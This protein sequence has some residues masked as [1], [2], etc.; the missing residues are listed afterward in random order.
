MFTLVLLPV[1]WPEKKNESGTGRLTVLNPLS[2][3]NR[4]ESVRFR[5]IDVKNA[6]RVLLVVYRNYIHNAL[7]GNVRIKI[8]VVQGNRRTSSQ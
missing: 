3:A 6:K 5:Q 7:Y 4:L 8:V 2:Q 1:A